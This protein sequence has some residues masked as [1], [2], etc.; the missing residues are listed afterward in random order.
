MRLITVVR[1][2]RHIVHADLDLFSIHCPPIGVPFMADDTAFANLHHALEH[3]CERVNKPRS[4]VLFRRGDKA[5]GLFVILS[6]KVSLDLGVDSA[7]CRTYGPGA[8]VGLP[9]TLTRHNY[10]MTATVTEDAELGF[11]SPDELDSLLRQRPDLCQ[12]RLAIL[13]MKIAE[14]HETERVLLTRDRQTAK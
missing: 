7:L 4:A 13:G 8:L 2:M 1:D 5:A 3:R 10:S 12:L 11:W 9:S 14:G 6:G